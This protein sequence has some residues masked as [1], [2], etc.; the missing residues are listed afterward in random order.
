MIGFLKGKSAIGLARRQGKERN[1]TR[2]HLWSRGY[3]VSRVGFNEEQIRCYIRE[4]KGAD[5]EGR[6]SVQR[7]ICSGQP[8]LRRHG[9]SSHRQCRWCL[10]LMAYPK[11][12]QLRLR[13]SNL[14]ERV[15]REL[16]RRTRVIG[17]VPKSVW[18]ERLATGVLIEI[19]ED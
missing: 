8:S 10:T 14:S 5:G 13:A 18:L 2:E 4:Q 12:Q 19:D 16:K 7:A 9:S 6:F 15:N 1:Y 17:V 3:A 11:E